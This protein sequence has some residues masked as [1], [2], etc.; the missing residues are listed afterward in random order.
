MKYN[1][2]WPITRRWKEENVAAEDT[3]KIGI[4]F[5][6]YQFSQISRKTSMEVYITNWK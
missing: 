5:F 3:Q 1:F 2:K 6:L 4:N